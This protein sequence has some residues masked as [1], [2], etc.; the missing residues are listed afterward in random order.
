MYLT[1][2]RKPYANKFLVYLRN[3]VK[4]LFVR[5]SSTSQISGTWS[6]IIGSPVARLK[7]RYR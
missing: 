1:L 5:Q 2:Y 4:S 7:D 3:R 6:T